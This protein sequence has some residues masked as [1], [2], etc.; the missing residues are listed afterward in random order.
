MTVSIRSVCT[1][2]LNGIVSIL[3][4]YIEHTA[5]TFDT[6]PYST[7]TRLPWLQQFAQG[8]RYRCLVAELDGKVVGYA[9]TSAFRPKRAYDTSVEVSIYV[10]SGN[11]GKGIG[12]LLYKA[13]MDSVRDEDIH[14][15]HALIT[16]PNDKS[17]QL[18][19]KF[20][21]SVV[22]TLDE[23]G[24]KFGKYHSVCLMEKKL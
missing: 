4:H 6:D 16:L 8:G 17:I 19:K 20:G 12:R 13:L 24:R 7:E 9:N 22:G 21:F 14:R 11:E 15:M 10:K 3:N 23:A 18:H 5:I 1:E 2:D